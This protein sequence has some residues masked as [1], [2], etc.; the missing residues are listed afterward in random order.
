MNL[1]LLSLNDFA[2]N[3]YS[4]KSNINPNGIRKRKKYARL[5]D[6]GNSFKFLIV[7][8]RRDER[9]ISLYQKVN[10]LILEKFG[11]ANLLKSSLKL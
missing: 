2:P 11:F 10:N 5:V 8:E 6:R 1:N 7:K 4:F 3:E 9:Q